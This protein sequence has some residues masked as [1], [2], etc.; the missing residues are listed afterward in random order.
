MAPRILRMPPQQLDQVRTGTAAKIGDRPRRAQSKMLR[1]PA[2]VAARA[3]ETV[4]RPD[5]ARGRRR[6]GL[7]HVGDARRFAGADRVFQP[8]P[9]VPQFRVEQD[10]AAKVLGRRFQQITT[11]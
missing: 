2:I 7:K 6:R 9:F 4:H 1:R 3:H 10:H 11:R 5:K 8:A